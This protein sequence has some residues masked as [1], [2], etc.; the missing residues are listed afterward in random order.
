MMSSSPLGHLH[1]FVGFIN[2]ALQ[3]YTIPPKWVSVKWGPH[4]SAFCRKTAMFINIADTKQFI[5]STG[6]SNCRC[7]SVD[8]LFPARNVG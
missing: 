8:Q 7:K 6:I 2:M 3:N 5:I 1:F 4:K